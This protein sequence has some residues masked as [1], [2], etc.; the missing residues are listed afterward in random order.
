[1]KILKLDLHAY[2]Q[3]RN[4]SF[5]F[6]PKC[7]FQVLYGANEAGK[8]TFSRAYKALLFG[9]DKNMPGD[10]VVDKDSLLIEGVLELDKGCLLNV[11]R[12]Y[13]LSRKLND[14]FSEFYP[15]INKELFD[16]FCF[17]SQDSI[18]LGSK[19][20]L[21]NLKH[22]DLTLFNAAFGSGKI[23]DLIR[24][25]DNEAS[26]LF[27]PKGSKPDIN[28][29]LKEFS[30]NEENI[31][32]GRCDYSSWNAL[33]KE[34]E[35]CKRA[36]QSLES[37]IEKLV[38]KQSSLRQKVELLALVE[39]LHFIK[40]EL[41]SIY[42]GFVGLTGYEQLF[43]I[44]SRI[45]ENKDVL[46]KSKEL[47]CSCEKKL[48][49]FDVNSSLILN[50]RA[51]TALISS[52]TAYLN[53]LDPHEKS[54]KDL[55]LVKSQL[56]EAKE[57][58][59]KYTLSP[60]V[61]NQ[62]E[63]E[64]LKRFQ[65]RYSS[66]TEKLASLTVN[67]DKTKK[68]YESKCKAKFNEGFIEGLDEI[69]TDIYIFKDKFL[70]YSKL[71][72][73]CE[74]E[75]KL[76]KKEISLQ[77]CSLQIPLNYNFSSEE[78]K[79]LISKIE[80]LR[81]DKN[82]IQ[83]IETSNQVEID[84]LSDISSCNKFLVSFESLKSKRKKLGTKISGN[85][86]NF[87]KQKILTLFGEYHQ[88]I[89][90]E[91]LFF[92][93]NFGNSQAYL[94]E[95]AF[96]INKSKLYSIRGAV[97]LASISMIYKEKELLQELKTVFEIEEISH[98]N[99]H[100]SK[101]ID[102]LNYLALQKE[103]LEFETVKYS[104]VFSQVSDLKI[105]IYGHLKG[106]GVSCEEDLGLFFKSID[107]F[108][109]D[110]RSKNNQKL[111]RR[112]QKEALKNQLQDIA[113]SI[114]EINSK[115]AE[116]IDSWNQLQK[117]Y[118]F[119][120]EISEIDLLLNSHTGLI[121][122]QK[123][124]DLKL[125]LNKELS[126]QI[127]KYKKQ[128]KAFLA[129]DESFKHYEI[130]DIYQLQSDL[131][132]SLE[133]ESLK[134]NLVKKINE[135]RQTLLD[136]EK[137]Q[138]KYIGKLHSKLSNSK[139]ELE[140]LELIL[141]RSEDFVSFSTKYAK[142]KSRLLESFSDKELDEFLSMN[143]C[144]LK[145]SIE[146]ELSIFSTKFLE[147]TEEKNA[148]EQ[149]IGK[150]EYQTKQYI[151][152]NRQSDLEVSQQDIL[153]DLHENA[154]KYIKLKA[155]LFI[156]KKVIWDLQVNHQKEFLERTS[157]FFN[158]FTLGKYKRVVLNLLDQKSF[159]VCYDAN[160]ISVS[161]DLLSEGTRDQLFLAIKLTAIEMF[162]GSKESFPLVLDDLLVNYDDL[163]AKGT[164]KVLE[165]LSKSRQIIFLTHH[166]HIINLI[167]ESLCADSYQLHSL[168]STERVLSGS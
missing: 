130:N 65:S 68:I 90:N 140:Q 22:F 2:A 46:N 50:Q 158:S 25:L 115:Q 151:N 111:E 166:K 14:K 98:E 133:K 114:E 48:K 82:E 38:L 18:R 121:A 74:T 101:L 164:L 7:S 1:M 47:V 148:L 10:F 45:S 86:Q 88:L 124:Y 102:I 142:V 32:L 93:K 3:Y 112:Y 147:Q 116:E 64:N 12:E 165:E 5:S 23:K 122:L 150:L 135:N 40:H 53:F 120:C 119:R 145:E 163:R 57:M 136:T 36:N 61:F 127:D 58:L 51:V 143:I 29:L 35:S 34:I 126:K 43:H 17:L 99:F 54:L 56:E 66:Y 9:I 75:I 106:L 100:S 97:K 28:L 113:T 80:K 8:T 138:D 117:E 153:F 77:L 149:K 76:L 168:G 30:S 131:E 109:R 89:K 26:A 31:S 156:L 152:L 62:L 72:D 4:K 128:F 49:T 24:T 73:S 104:E 39:E 37:S 15:H 83:K 157:F 123:E 146:K 91:D 107:N 160:G 63:L 71:L 105:D 11:K 108:V 125:N 141:D 13:R 139:I 162:N 85:L 167:K 16:L 154:E 69:S 92:E 81:F 19:E 42:P 70:S 21:E 94:N 144:E 6:D 87:S 137:Q 41:T 55:L 79:L 84:S 129:L 159:L 20:L 60:R 155:T 52:F 44:L 110:L 118:G 132:D 78:L 33:N 134:Q 27:K 96:Q 103:K 95:V 59:L 161:I 67:F